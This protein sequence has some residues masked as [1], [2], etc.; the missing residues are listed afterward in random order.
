LAT[1]GNVDIAAIFALGKSMMQVGTEIAKVIKKAQA[2]PDVARRVLLY[3]ESAQ[4]A[5]SALGLE[6]QRILSEVRVCDVGDPQQLKSLWTRLD[7]Y[8]HE[9]NIRPLLKKAVIGMNACRLSIEKESEAGWWRRHDKKAAVT[10]FSKTL[11]ELESELQSLRLNFLPGSDSGMGVQTLVPIF[12]LIS[13]PDK[14]MRHFKD[15]E[16]EGVNE[17]LGKRALQ[18]LRDPSHEKWFL[19]TGKVEGLVVALQLAFS[20][21]LT[22]SVSKDAA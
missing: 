3:L 14:K 17:E 6:R 10:E 4:A 20:V 5:I 1:G 16:I 12:D 2:A 18:A 21:K 8:L 9:D 11:N 15:S 19:L 22:S 13:T 7:S